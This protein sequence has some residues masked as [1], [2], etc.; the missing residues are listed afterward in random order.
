M[1]DHEGDGAPAIALARLTKEYPGGAAALAGLSL[2]VARGE[3]FGL[4]GPNGSGKT[5]TVRILVTLLPKTAGEARV[6]G[7]DTEREAGYVRQLIG[8]A[9][10][11]IP[12]RFVGSA[13]LHGPSTPRPY[14][15]GG[16]RRAVALPTG[17]HATIPLRS[18]SREGT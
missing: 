14:Q 4:L 17:H 18:R 5:T 12:L 10:Q 9:G 7:F 1:T 2:S 16:A 3:V 11:S 13:G 6:G 15:I 8:Y